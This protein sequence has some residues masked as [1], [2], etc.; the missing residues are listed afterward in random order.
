M[1]RA[2]QSR[3]QAFGLQ[4]AK[5]RAGLGW[6]SGRYALSA[7]CPVVAGARPGGGARAPGGPFGLATFSVIR[8]IL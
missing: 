1:K 5:S 2:L 6:H 7:P 3:K 8:V 4:L